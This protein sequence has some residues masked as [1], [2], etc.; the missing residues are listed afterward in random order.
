M[1]RGPIGDLVAM[2]ERTATSVEAVCDTYRRQAEAAET[3]IIQLLLSNG[4]SLPM[5]YDLYAEAN[6]GVW[7]LHEGDGRMWIEKGRGK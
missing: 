4:G 5:K 6:S 3:L 1:N 7:E 2:I